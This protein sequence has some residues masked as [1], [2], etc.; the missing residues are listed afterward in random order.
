MPEHEFEAENPV[1]HALLEHLIV[2]LEKMN[3]HLDSFELLTEVCLAAAAYTF[4]RSGGSSEEFIEMMKFMFSE[5]YKLIEHK[6]KEFQRMVEVIKS[7][8]KQ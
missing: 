2:E 4:Y 1:T 6:E 3:K 5:K 7:I 8:G